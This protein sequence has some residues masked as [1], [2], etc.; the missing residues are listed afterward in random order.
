MGFRR[1]QA[2]EDVKHKILGCEN[3]VLDERSDTDHEKSLTPSAWDQ[4]HS[5]E[6][7]PHH[8]PSLVEDIKAVSILQKVGVKNI[9]WL[10]V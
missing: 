7:A 3:T 6:Y 9:N 4:A 8:H 1:L 5:R 10:R 2:E